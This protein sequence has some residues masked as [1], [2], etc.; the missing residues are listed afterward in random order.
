M[1]IALISTYNHP[2]ALGLRYVSSYLK[3]AGQDVQVFFM[4]S[5]RDT[6]KA[7]FAEPAVA[8]LLERLRDRDV[9]G[10]DEL[11]DTEHGLRRNREDIEGAVTNWFARY[12]DQ[13][14]RR[15]ESQS[16]GI[17]HGGDRKIEIAD[18]S[19]SL[20]NKR[21]E[22]RHGPQNT[23]GLQVAYRAFHRD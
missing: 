22:S 11:A 16:M 23:R 9:I 13:L 21:S 17:F 12:R 19:P 3:A 18:E 4:S 1:R 8:E 2:V 10:M 6:A 5:K 7:D 14:D 15:L 20:P